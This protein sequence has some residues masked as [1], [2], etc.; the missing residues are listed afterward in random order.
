MTNLQNGTFYYLVQ[1][2]LSKEYESVEELNKAIEKIRGRKR[3]PFFSVPYRIVVKK[4]EVSWFELGEWKI[5]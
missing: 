1:G 5:S 3:K 2:I 4:T